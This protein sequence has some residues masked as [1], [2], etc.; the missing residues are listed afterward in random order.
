MKATL[1]KKQNLA[2]AERWI[3][4]V[5]GSAMAFYALKRRSRQSLL[6]SAA[7]AYLINRGVK[8]N[9]AIYNAL[10]VH[11]ENGRKRGVVSVP[12]GEGVKLEKTVTINRGAEELYEFW[13]DFENLPLFMKHLE[14]VQVFDDG[15]SRWRAKAPA[16][17]DVE[18]MAQIH[19]EIPYQLI[20]WRSVENSEVDHA[21][22]VEF[23]AAPGG[24]GTEV[25]VVINYKPPAGKLG[26]WIAKMFGEEPSQQVEDD[27]NRFKQLMEA[28]EIPTTKG[29]PTAAKK[30]SQLID[31]AME[32]K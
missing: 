14:S 9:C 13:R 22:S 5:A 25:K 7:G 27:L 26:V 6:W 16:G 31:E 12:H 17:Q 28:G 3:S 11:P 30:G 24:R 1:M 4:L 19:N 29:Q 20:A 8:G 21:G 32:L 15:R 10:G 18:W 2:Q 23:K